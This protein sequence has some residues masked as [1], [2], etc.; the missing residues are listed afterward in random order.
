M[1]ISIFGTSSRS[2]LFRLMVAHVLGTLFAYTVYINVSSLGDGYRPEAFESTR[3]LYTDGLSSTILVY[4]IYFVLSTALP[5][6][7]FLVPMALGLVVAIMTWHAFRDVYTYIG[8]KLFW[9]C[10]LLPHFLVWSGSSS[11]EQIIIIAGIIIINFAAKRSFAD[12]KLTINLIFVLIALWFIYFIRPNYFIIYL[13]IFLTAFFSPWIHKIISKRLSV[14]VWLLAFILAIMALTFILSQHPTF[15]SEDVVVFMK[16]VQYSFLA[17]TTAGSNRTDIKWNDISDFMYNS[18]WAI[19]QGFIGPTLFEIISKPIQIPA[20]IEGLIY[21]AILSY[22]FVRLLQLAT[23][24]RT[25]R[26]HILP[27]MFVAFVVIFVSYPFL[28]FNPG[29]AL[30]YKQ[31]MHPILIFYPL[32]ILAY[33]RRNHLMRTNIKKMSD[34]C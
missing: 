18:L 9:V 26:I 19:P 22:L 13:I 30:R 27:Y 12:N 25:Q 23:V 1:K 16:K 7:I 34:A 3:A 6:F 28:M 17:Y 24:S 14:G 10:N 32:L 20:F 5:G 33:N 29:S 31:S 8:R 15:F 4:G 2:L 11:K 21:I